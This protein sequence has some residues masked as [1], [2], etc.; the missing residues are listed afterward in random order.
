MCPHA[1]REG[2]EKGVNHHHKE[3]FGGGGGVGNG[4]SEVL[5]L[6][7]LSFSPN[8]ALGAFGL[9]LLSLLLIVV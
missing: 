5:I 4:R 1:S 9:I 6:T 2:K 7:C 3:K 8:T